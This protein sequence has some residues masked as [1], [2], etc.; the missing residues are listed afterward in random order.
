MFLDA[1]RVESGKQLEA[2]IC[3]VGGGA[4]GITLAREFN[5]GGAKVI[6]LESGGLRQHR[7]TQALY[8]GENTGLNYELDTTR[9]RFF[10][11]STNCW[12]GWCRPLSELDFSPREWVNNS[13]WPIERQ[14]LEPYYERAHHVANIIPGEYDPETWLKKARQTNPD[15]E[16]L[17]FSSDRVETRIAQLTPTP[18]FG[19][20]YREELRQSDNVQ[21][22]F[23]AN[24]S[25]FRTNAEGNRV[26][27]VDV[28]CLNGNHF[29]VKAKTFVLAT[30]GIENARL[31]LLSND[32]HKNGL[33]N[34]NDLVGRFFMEHPRIV[35]GEIEFFKDIRPDL[36]DTGYA[37]FN[38]PV[39][40]SLGLSPDTQRQEQ[41]L[42]YHAY[43]EAIYEGE[44]S[45]GAQDLKD[46]YVRLRK[47]D[48]PPEIFSMLGH[49]ARDLP[50]VYKYFVGKRLRAEKYMRTHKLVNILEPEPHGESRITLSNS[51]DALGLNRVRMNWMLTPK[52]HR[53]LLRSQQII[54]EELERAG[55]GRLKIDPALEEGEWGGPVEWVW[56]HMGSTRMDPDPKKGVVDTDCRVHG[57][58]NL[59]VAGSS[60]YPTVS[61]D[62]P[63][64]TVI[65]LALR[66]ADHIKAGLRMRPSK[67]A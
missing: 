56:H 35:T 32:V 3:I 38:A 55:I 28:V 19:R 30:G 63:T 48:V 31:L 1:R 61:A 65:A 21:L 15:L 27:R 58:A 22:Y 39:I 46:L 18:R 51:R 16:L 25:G 62:T 49:I 43:V 26:E 29:T 47:Q 7:K 37:Y 4:A 14:T 8:K 9:T 53:T 60:V 20:E 33:G 42:N 44:D 11:G 54:G 10:G 67:A 23:R 5:H 17:R 34:Q 59:Y 52:V 6:L 64:L 66:M 45:Q 36:Y 12:G 13:G 2:D 24:I 40:A 41:L 57:V 50:Q